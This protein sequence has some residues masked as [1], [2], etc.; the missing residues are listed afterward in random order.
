[1]TVARAE[2]MIGKHEQLRA[3]VEPLQNPQD[4]DVT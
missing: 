4:P 1:M 2:A 3:V